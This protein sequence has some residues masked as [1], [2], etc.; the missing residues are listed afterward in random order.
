MAA[1]KSWDSYDKFSGEVARQRR[2]VRTAHTES[3]L[4]AVAASCKTRLRTVPQGRVLWRAQL[5]NGETLDEYGV[6][7]DAAF[8]PIRMKPRTERALEGRANPKGIPCLYLSTTANA[9]MSE[10]RPWIGALISAAQFKITR[11]LTI[12]DCSVLHGQY[13][14]LANAAQMS[15]LFD[16]PAPKDDEID[17]IVWAA[18]DNAFSK[19]VT[20]TDD[21]AEYAATQTL[22]ELFREEGYDGIAYKSALGSDGYSVALFN[23]DDARQLNGRLYR[24]ERIDFKFSEY[25]DEYFIQ[26]DGTVA[27]NAIVAYHPIKKQ[28]PDAE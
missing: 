19:P 2:Y 27:R 16:G 20:E 6:G 11:G 7:H 12:V 24:V 26:K 3:F 9:A 23:L 13:V 14:K 1:F 18:I 17:N 10:V 22:A 28:T 4:R 5:G 8:A 15:A 21:I 25:K